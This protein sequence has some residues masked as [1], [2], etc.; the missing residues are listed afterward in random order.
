MLRVGKQSL[1]RKIIVSVILCLIMV[2]GSTT[3]LSIRIAK[4]NLYKEME[5]QGKEMV[6]LALYQA[7]MQDVMLDDIEEI[8]NN[9]LYDSAFSIA[10]MSTYSN[11][12]LEALSQKTGLA[13]I[14][15][16]NESGKIVYSNMVG[17][18]GYIYGENHAMQ[19]VLKGN[20][21][22]IT[23]SIR[24]SEVDSRFYKYGGVKL[25]HGKGAV[26]I[27]IAAD[28][29]EKMKTNFSIQR[30]LES[31]G[32]EDR[33]VYAL[34]V[35]KS[36]T[37][38]AHSDK[39][40]I[41]MVF[42]YPGERMAVEKGEE[43]TGIF[44]SE[45]RG[46]N[47]YEVILPFH[48]Q[49]GEIIGAI[50]MGLS[51]AP[52]EDAVKE[53]VF[54]SIMVAAITSMIGILFILLFIQRLIK[55]VKYLAAAANQISL[56]DLREK[57]E[58]DSKDEI[59]SL[60]HSFSTMVDSVKNI[61]KKILNTSADMNTFSDELVASAQQNAA[62]ADQIA[63]ATEAVAAGAS[64]QVKKTNGVK[65]KVTIVSGKI[66]GVVSNIEELKAS[67]EG[68]VRSS[69]E[70]RAE[71]L[72]MNQQMDT[73]R[74]SSHLS[75]ST[76]KNL[77]NTS[78][79]IGKI[80]DVIKQIAN[81]TNLLALNAAIEA[82]RAGEAGKG[83]SVVADEIRTL[84]EQSVRSVE[85][86]TKLIEETQEKSQVAIVTIDDSVSEVD[87][88]MQI[89]EKVVNSFDT[90]SST[91]NENQQLFFQLESAMADLND[92]FNNTMV[93]INDIEFIAEETAANTE[94]V[95]AS[96][97]E[98]MASIQQIT[99]SIEHLNMMVGELNNL[100]AQFK[101]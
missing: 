40:R 55:P 76:I 20:Q 19:Q 100:I 1:A 16:I 18:I 9:Y 23:E 36:L 8:L 101:I 33:V 79:K 6:R 21:E 5:L 52:V 86:I 46:M 12:I 64:E 53:M 49:S 61:I 28:E 66:E 90:I 88:G 73:I 74:Q 39:E 95:A 7:R 44:H 91:I 69:R 59:G 78:Q 22:K 83:F 10:S 67:T 47:I 45:E 27:G 30:L 84:A 4:E 93:L 82:A 98:Q 32:Q 43:H 94:E 2:I 42:D 37:A 99:S 75:G 26:Q 70:S 29:I 11:D 89:V 80:V 97:E 87:K 71:L 41:G 58:V 72:E 31:M 85:D 96:T 17:N 60:A 54:Q 77:N 56:G 48:N 51:V 25:I 63:K 62:V 65:E 34:I 3:I 15:I 14:N 24:Q 35:D 68:M 57:I 50:N 13:E 92:N 38:I 81:Q